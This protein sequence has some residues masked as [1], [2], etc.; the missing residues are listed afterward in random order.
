MMQNSFLIFSNTDLSLSFFFQLH[1]KEMA[2]EYG[3]V[4][5]GDDSEEEV[6]SCLYCPACNKSFRTEKA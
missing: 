1:L 5:S 4:N 2:G 6:V 3:D